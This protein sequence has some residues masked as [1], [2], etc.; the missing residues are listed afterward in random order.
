[1]SDKGEEGSIKSKGRK[2]NHQ[3]DVRAE[4]IKMN[5][6][7]TFNKSHDNNNPTAAHRSRVKPGQ[8]KTAGDIHG[9]HRDNRPNKA[10]N[11]LMKRATGPQPNTT[12]NDEVITHDDRKLTFSAVSDPVDQAVPSDNQHYRGDEISQKHII[13]TSTGAT[14]N[15]SRFQIPLNDHI[16]LKVVGQ[17]QKADNS[18]ISDVT[19]NK[20]LVESDDVV[21]FHFKDND[22]DDIRFRVNN[23]G[24][25]VVINGKTYKSEILTNN[26]VCVEFK[27]K[28]GSGNTWVWSVNQSLRTCHGWSSRLFTTIEMNSILLNDSITMINNKRC[29][30]NKS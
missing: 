9:N 18:A 28:N 27:Y 20:V 24:N 2:S 12:H 15:H 26:G 13:A 22:Q 11:Q 25:Y 7:V 5:V 17:E 1:M 4:S 29:V 23:L 3:G 8:S 30:L 19:Q 10:S 6:K 16:K 21:Y 14:M